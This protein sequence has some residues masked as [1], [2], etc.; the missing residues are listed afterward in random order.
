MAGELCIKREEKSDEQCGQPCLDVYDKGS[1][2]TLRGSKE[3]GR[4]EGDIRTER[5]KEK[6]ERRGGNGATNG[7]ICCQTATLTRGE[8]LVRHYC[9]GQRGEKR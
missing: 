8:N 1:I 7:G 9:G 6:R 3:R 4:E 2:L 5:K